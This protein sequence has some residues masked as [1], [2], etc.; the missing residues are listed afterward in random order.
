VLVVVSGP[1]THLLRRGGSPTIW[2][3]VRPHRG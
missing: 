1:D 3:R 2:V